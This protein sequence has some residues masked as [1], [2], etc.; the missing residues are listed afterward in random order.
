MS[1][2]DKIQKLG[3]CR[4]CLNETSG[5]HLKR[6]DVLVYT[7]PEQCERCKEVKYVIFKVKF[8]SR[9]KLWFKRIKK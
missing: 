4:S 1:K 7:Y 9:W 6:K 2:A 5:L 8:L 3:Y